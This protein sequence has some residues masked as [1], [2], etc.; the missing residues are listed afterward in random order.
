MTRAGVYAKS[1]PTKLPPPP[2]QRK[3]TTNQPGGGGGGG[4]DDERKLARDE[5][6]DADYTRAY[7]LGVARKWMQQYQQAE[8]ARRQQRAT[9]QKTRR[10]RRLWATRKMTTKWLRGKVMFVG[11]GRAGKTATMRS[12]LRLPFDPALGSTVGATTNNV[13]QVGG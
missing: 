10:V 8:Q 11:E 6:N 3:P 2:K 1:Q 5:E 13:C 12:L 4:G 9:E 7:Y